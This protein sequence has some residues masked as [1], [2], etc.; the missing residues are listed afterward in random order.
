MFTRLG[1]GLDR[2]RKRSLFAALTV[3]LGGGIA[4]GLFGW[5]GFTSVVASTN[6]MEFCISCHEMREFVYAEYQQTH[7]FSNPS[8]VQ[9]TCADCHVPRAFWPKMMRKVQATLVEVPAKVMGTIATR[10]LFEAKRMELA[11]SVWAGMKAN[12]SR[13]CRECHK[14]NA[15]ALADQRPRSRAQHE[16]AKTSGET[17]ID[18]HQG[19]AH[20]KPEEP[21]KPGEEEDFA[22]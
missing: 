1:R 7:H 14:F 21:E 18:C 8:G 4:V 10:E 16:D 15:M 20:R 17:C 22:L 6:T 13:E 9:A 19:I 11:R 12:D 5:V 2:I 3:L